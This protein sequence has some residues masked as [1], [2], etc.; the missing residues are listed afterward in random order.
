MTVR[1]RCYLDHQNFFYNTVLPYGVRWLDLVKMLQAIL[2]HHYPFLKIEME[3]VFV[4]GT[5]LSGKANDHQSI[6]FNALKEHSKERI[7]IILGDTSP[8]TMRWSLTN[9]KGVDEGAVSIRMRRE[10]HTDVNIAC[11]IVE[12]AY[13][14]LSVGHCDFEV[15]CLI[16]NDRDL[17]RPLEIKRELGQRVILVTPRRRGVSDPAS[18]SLRRL[19][20]KADRIP[21][22]EREHLVNSRLPAKIGKFTCPPDWLK[23]AST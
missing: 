20:E 4:F 10:K 7:E 18:K 11:A 3:K 8:T 16:S 13:K 15:C 9:D 23:E 21:S 6:Y 17:T 12:D 22:I 2:Q 5:S 14:H 19:V 1:V